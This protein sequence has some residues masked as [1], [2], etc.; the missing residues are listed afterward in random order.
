MDDLQRQVIL[1]YMRANKFFSKIEDIEAKVDAWAD[2]YPI[3]ILSELKKLNSY[4]ASNPE[5]AKSY[6]N[7]SAFINNNLNRASGPPAFR[8]ASVNEI[9]KKLEVN[10]FKKLDMKEG[11]KT[12]KVNYAER[13][14]DLKAQAQRL[15][16]GEAKG[17]TNAKT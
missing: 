11:I 4:L 8:P 3:D 2:A 14:Q 15:L 10:L 9:M 17:G 16:E 6:K 13:L 5:K 12:K 7:F 1:D